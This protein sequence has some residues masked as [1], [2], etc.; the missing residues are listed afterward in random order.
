MS[1][2]KEELQTFAV[3]IIILNLHNKSLYYYRKE[4]GNPKYSH[5]LRSVICICVLI[6]TRISSFSGIGLLK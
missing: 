6:T 5:A 3:S 1:G 4:S 2:A